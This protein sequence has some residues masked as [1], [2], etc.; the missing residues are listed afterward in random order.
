M[1]RVLDDDEGEIP[2]SIPTWSHAQTL[3]DLRMAP[4]RTRV[5]MM[6]LY[7]HKRTVM[8]LLIRI[9]KFPLISD[10]VIQ[11]D[12]SIFEANEKIKLQTLSYERTEGAVRDFFQVAGNDEV[13]EGRFMDLINSLIEDGFTSE[14]IWKPMLRIVTRVRQAGTS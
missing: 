1:I 9:S 13:A 12:I 2:S 14:A 7:G 11:G 10:E 6:R 3:I 4:K 5:E 8:V